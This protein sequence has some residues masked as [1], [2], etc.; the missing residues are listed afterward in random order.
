MKQLEA[1]NCAYNRENFKRELCLKIINSFSII[2]CR[3]VVT[4]CSKNASW[5]NRNGGHKQLLGDGTAPLGPTVATALATN[6]NNDTT[7]TNFVNLRLKNNKAAF[8]TRAA[9]S[10]LNSKKVGFVPN[11]KKPHVNKQKAINSKSRLSSFV[12]PNSKNSI[13]LPNLNSKKLNWFLMF[14]WAKT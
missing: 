3:L 14:G 1:S 6:T 9:K 2:A 8:W 13:F 10:N 12:S 11:S 7:V 5:I 4:R